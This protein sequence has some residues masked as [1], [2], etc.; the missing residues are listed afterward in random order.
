MI[1]LS[2]MVTSDAREIFNSFIVNAVYIYIYDHFG[3]NHANHGG[4]C[5]IVAEILVD[6]REMR[7]LIE[8]LYPFDQLES[9]T[10]HLAAIMAFELAALL[11]SSTGNDSLHHYVNT[12][13]VWSVR[14]SQWP[15]Q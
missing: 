2:F 13:A 14:P 7:A 6:Y 11:L 10:A 15:F 12:A 1:P 8:A 9:W 3:S 5:P 4:F